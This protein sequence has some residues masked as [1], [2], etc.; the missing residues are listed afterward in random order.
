MRSRV[1]RFFAKPPAERRALFLACIYTSMV[2]IALRV[3]SF[4][5]VLR[6]VDRR[7]RRPAPIL[8]RLEPLVLARTVKGVGR[9]LLKRSST[10][11]LTEALVGLILFRRA[12]RTARLRIG[13]TRREGSVEDSPLAAHAWLESDARVVIGGVDAPSRYE[14]F[15]EAGLLEAHAR[16][17]RPPGSLPGSGSTTR[18][19]VPWRR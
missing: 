1:R 18:R 7:S 5:S 9:V 17:P 14:S 19:G 13:A 8:A 12:G 15:P 6:F 11:C 4:A 3:L 16:S 2:W 10:P